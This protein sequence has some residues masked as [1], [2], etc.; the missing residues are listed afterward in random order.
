MSSFST[1]LPSLPKEYDL[2]NNIILNVHDTG[3]LALKYQDPHR[4]QGLK[5]LVDYTQK[6]QTII[7][8]LL[9]ESNPRM[10]MIGNPFWIKKPVNKGGIPT[11]F[12]RGNPNRINKKTHGEMA[13]LHV[14]TATGRHLFE[15]GYI[16]K[17]GTFPPLRVLPQT[18]HKTAERIKEVGLDTLYRQ[19]KQE[20]REA[21]RAEK[22]A[23]AP[24][25]PRE[26]NDE[27]NGNETDR[28]EIDTKAKT[29]WQAV[30]DIFKAIAAFFVF[31]C[32]FGQVKLFAES[33]PLVDQ[34]MPLIQ[35]TLKNRVRKENESPDTSA[36]SEEED[37][38]TLV[39]RELGDPSEELKILL[40]TSSTEKSPLVGG[41]TGV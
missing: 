38:G 8:H 9:A 4:E 39:I 36:S 3:L 15:A 7:P 10:K 18:L 29:V 2:G 27:V 24:L 1:L 37:R 16:D 26:I 17:R 31:V 32:T 25:S 6:L 41:L 35:L 5:K 13:Q 11:I 28:E 14:K 22:E 34:E 12:L 33:P 20:E 21:L 19:F 40:G 23:S 30:K